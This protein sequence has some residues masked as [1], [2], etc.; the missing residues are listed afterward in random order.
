MYIVR[1][2]VLGIAILVGCA[3]S[4]GRAQTIAETIT[5]WGLLGEW[6]IDCKQQVTD[7]PSA[8]L[9]YEV[10][11]GNP[12]QVRHLGKDGDD[13]SRISRAM[14]APDGSLEVVIEYG[15]NIGPFEIAFIRGPNQQIRAKSSRK[16]GGKYT[17][18]DGKFVDGGRPSLWQTRCQ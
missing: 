12:V 18:F 10:R 6:A 4:I 15:G 14:V 9:I 1:G 13:V 5:R 17:I 2:L 11:K 8:R 16:P 3:P 7:T